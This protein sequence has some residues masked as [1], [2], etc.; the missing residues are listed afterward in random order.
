MKHQLAVLI[1][2]T[3]AEA[4][5]DGIG[6]DSLHLPKSLPVSLPSSL[7]RQRPDI[8]AVGVACCIKPARMSGLPPPTFIR[9]SFFRAAWEASAPASPTAA[10]VWNVGASL[11]QPIFNGGAL[12]AEKR[13]ATRGLRGSGQRIPADRAAGFQGSGRR[14]ARHR[15]TMR[16]PCRLAP[17]RPRRRNHLRQSRRNA[18]TPEASAN[19]LCSMRSASICKPRSTAPP[20]RQ[21]LRR[22]RVPVPGAG[23]RMVER[24]A[25]DCAQFACQPKVAIA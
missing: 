1:G 11:A 7:V 8:R 21:P 20:L 17:K 16:R 25:N 3:P 19:S 18:L 5:I 24:G 4:Q 10:D 6:L 23:R 13:K 12:R 15:A 9:R 14:A 22:L 2:K